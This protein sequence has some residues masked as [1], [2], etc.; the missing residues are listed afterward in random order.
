MPYN[1]P[2]EQKEKQAELRKIQLD[3]DKSHTFGND[4][5]NPCKKGKKASTSLINLN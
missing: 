1:T 2:E 4:D 3:R 5:K